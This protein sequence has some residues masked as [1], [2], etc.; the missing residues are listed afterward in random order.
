MQQLEQDVEMRLGYV[1]EEANKSSRRAAWALEQVDAAQAASAE[2]EAKLCRL[3]MRSD[4][5]RKAA[6]VTAALAGGGNN[7]GLMVERTESLDTEYNGS[8]GGKL[9]GSNLA[10]LVSEGFLTL[11]DCWQSYLMYEY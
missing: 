8:I 1:T 11:F 9:M 3:R 4:Q 2:A 7:G 6:K 10:C 5:W